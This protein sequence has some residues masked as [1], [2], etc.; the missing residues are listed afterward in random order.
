MHDWS[1]DYISSAIR[2]RESAARD[3][4][5]AAIKWEV[6]RR[7]EQARDAYFEAWLKLKNRDWL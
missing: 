5:A 7:I 4:Y 1:G 6:R 3:L 2:A